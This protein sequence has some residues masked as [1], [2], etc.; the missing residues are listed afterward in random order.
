MIEASEYNAER[1]LAK[2]FNNF[3]SITNMI[4]VPDVILLLIGIKPVVG[5]LM[6]F[7]EISAT[8]LL[9]FITSDFLAFSLIK[10]IYLWVVKDLSLLKF[11]KFIMEDSTRFLRR[12]GELDATNLSNFA[13]S[14]R[15]VSQHAIGVSIGEFG[16]QTGRSVVVHMH[17]A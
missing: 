6:E 14:R 8:R 9:S 12:H 17:L 15:L 4:I 13:L 11:V 2:L 3:V 1:T 10:V 16:A 7:A 5:R